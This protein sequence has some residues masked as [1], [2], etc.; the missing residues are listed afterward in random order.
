LTSQRLDTKAAAEALDISMDALR[1]RVSR[2]HLDSEKGPDG[3]LYV[4]L[5]TDTPEQARDDRDQLIEVL[6]QQLDRAE[7]RDR[8]NRRIIAALTSRIPQLEPPRD[9]RDAPETATEP[10][11]STEPPASDAE[12]PRTSW[13]R[14]W[15]GFE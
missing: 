13:W 1:K 2:G 11:T 5:D 6:R 8:E 4:W 14:R 3:K 12:Q 15:F 9:E 10:E 7:E